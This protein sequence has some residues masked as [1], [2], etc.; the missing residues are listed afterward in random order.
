[1]YW[2]RVGWDVG[3]DRIDGGWSDGYMYECRWMKKKGDT[4]SY[5]YHGGMATNMSQIGGVRKGKGM[6]RAL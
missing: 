2:G 3:G 4:G 6:G 5:T 1:M